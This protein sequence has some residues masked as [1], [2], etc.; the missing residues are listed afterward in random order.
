MEIAKALV[1]AGGL[2]A[3][4]AGR[5]TCTRSMHLFPVANRPLLF[6]NLEALSAAGVLEATVLVEGEAGRA[7]REAVGDGR[8]WGMSL[9]CAEWRSSDGLGGALTAGRSFVGDEPVL[10]QQGGVLLRQR[11]NVHISAF[12]RERL[13]ALALR[14]VGDGSSGCA[15]P[16]PGYLLSARAISFLLDGPV[17]AES[18]VAGVRARGGRVRIERVDGCMPCD[19]DLE[20]L[21]DGNRRM[22][23]HLEPSLDGVL[24]DECRVQGAVEIH[25][26][27]TVARSLLRG[28]LIVGA[29][30]RIVDSY[31]GPYSS[32]GDDVVVEGTEIEHSI[33][34]PGASLRYI[35]ARVES[36]VIGRG[37]RVTRAFD[38]PS[39]VRMAIGD[40][41]E[42]ILG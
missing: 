14:L 26:T 40:G 8:Q 28:P 19:G 38:V 41:A 23:E 15:P 27:A 35:G 6:H 5:R 42:V 29:G 33:V 17:A 21:L 24:L 2:D 22:L 3:H 37:A 31:I 12:K 4:H 7:I 10:I 16:A 18:P 25:P 20:T 39:A 32:I 11:I 34:L 36:S 9:R 30:A 1:L 13:D